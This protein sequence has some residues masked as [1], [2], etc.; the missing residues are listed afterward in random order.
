MDSWR[1]GWCIKGKIR[2]LIF[3]TC[4]LIL[5]YGSPNVCMFDCNRQQGSPCTLM[6]YILL[7]TMLSS[8][9]LSVFEIVIHLNLKGWPTECIYMEREEGEVTHNSS[10]KIQNAKCIA[11]ISVW[12]IMLKLSP[13]GDPQF[14]IQN[15][16]CIDARCMGWSWAHNCHLCQQLCRVANMINGRSIHRSQ[17]N[18]IGPFGEVWN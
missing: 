16:I 12:R 1:W 3:R 9:L 14:V 11:E 5:E 7:N 18:E 2:I 17:A 8:L 6:P 10:F 15:T 13:R 4:I